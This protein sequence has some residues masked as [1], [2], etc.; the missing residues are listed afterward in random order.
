MILKKTITQKIKI[1]KKK[2]NEKV[3]KNIFIS[4]HKDITLDVSYNKEA[5]QYNIT[6]IIYYQ[7]KEFK[8]NTRKFY[9]QYESTWKCVNKRRE[10]DK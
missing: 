1:K 6:T 5:I 8:N 10:K 2:E 3:K 7:N 4:Q 9:E